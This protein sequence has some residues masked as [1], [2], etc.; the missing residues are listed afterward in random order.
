MLQRKWPL[1]TIDLHER[2]LGKCSKKTWVWRSRTKVV[3]KPKLIAWSGWGWRWRMSG[4]KHLMRFHMFS[5]VAKPNSRWGAPTHS[6]PPKYPTTLPSI[7]TCL[8]QIWTK[9][10]HFF[11][12]VVKPIIIL[13][14]L[15]RT[16][17]VILCLWPCFF[18]YWLLKWRN[19]LPPYFTYNHGGGIFPLLW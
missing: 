19:Y 11:I 1:C 17:S 12:Q 14:I 7:L 3:T 16:F 10:T 5:I 8:I 4:S 2:N 6:F 15:L 18:F 9:T 13:L